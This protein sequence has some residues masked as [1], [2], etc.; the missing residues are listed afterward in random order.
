MREYT[1]YAEKSSTK[2][3]KGNL[4]VGKAKKWADLFLCRN[5]L[6]VSLWGWQSSVLERTQNLFDLWAK[7]LSLN[8]ASIRPNMFV[9]IECNHWH[10]GHFSNQDFG[11]TI[12]F[13]A[14]F[15]AKFRAS[16]RGQSPVFHVNRFNLCWNHFIGKGIL[17]PKL[18]HRDLSSSN[19][20]M[21]FPTPWA[22]QEITEMVPR[23]VPILILF[24]R[25]QAPL[26]WRIEL[27]IILKITQNPVS[28]WPTVMKMGKLSK[29]TK[30]NKVWKECPSILAKFNAFSRSPALV[31]IHQKLLWRQLALE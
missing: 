23:I 28:S 12:K 5:I 11:C 8:V 16:K 31:S 6:V 27:M 19:I 3:G 18:S 24:Q 30:W 7:N 13:T 4:E 29:E 25:R 15:R 20:F 26:C 17:T 9:W 10:K 14:K 21:Y 2:W 1:V 22:L